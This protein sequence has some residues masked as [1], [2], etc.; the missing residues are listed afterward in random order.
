MK[1]LL[2][3]GGS[4]FVNKV[5]LT[6]L[7]FNY[8]DVLGI[9]NPPLNIPCH[10][11]LGV[12]DIHPITA[13][14]TELITKSNGY[15][16]VHTGH[17]DLAERTLCYRYYSSSASVDFACLKG[18]KTAYLIGVDLKETTEP[19]DHWHGVKNTS[20]M[21][22]EALQDEKKAIYKYCNKMKIYQC[23]PRVA[24]E[25]QIPYFNVKDLKY[26]S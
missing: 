3:I 5:N 22:I 24:N 20:H 15:K 2:I 25:W 14:K 12:D 7:D 9:N 13:P 10:Y 18:Y 17:S 8:Y 11:V 23:N 6:A 16:F 4:P 21:H 26:K 1:E 19:F